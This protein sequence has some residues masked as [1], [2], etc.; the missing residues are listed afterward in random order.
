MNIRIIL[1][2]LVVGLISFGGFLYSSQCVE[3]KTKEIDI[4]FRGEARSNSLYASR[5]FLKKMGIPAEKVDIY[6]LRDLPS[7]KTV[8]L[9]NTYR[10]TLVNY[11]INQ[12][13]DWVKGGGHLI[14]VVI[15]ERDIGEEGDLLQMKL[16]INTEEIYNFKSHFL[17]KQNEQ[18]KKDKKAGKKV[19]KNK[20]EFDPTFKVSF[21][22]SEKTY[23]LDFLTIDPLSILEDKTKKSDEIIMVDEAA[24][25]L[26]R[27]Y[28]KG[29]ISI[30]SDLDIIENRMIEDEDHA[31]FFWQLV[32]RKH[33]TIDNVWLINTD[34]MPSLIAWLWGYGWQIILTLSL[35][36]VFWLYSLSHRLGPVI[37]SE[38]LN[39]RRL[40]EHIQASGYFFWKKNQQD[41]LINSSQQA[42]LQK[43]GKLFPEW[44]QLTVDE[45]LALASEYTDIPIKELSPL[46]F[47]N[48][49]LTIDEFI[50]RIQQLEAIRKH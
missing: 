23:G 48:K 45:Q 34:E 12:L 24:Y 18:L 14:T 40:L 9:I 31:E 38:A 16:G 22:D 46:L 47:E 29:L 33:R 27:Q 5:L 1:G 7:K 39:R 17:E 37:P 4:G 43:I 2:V 20:V 49:T 44:S 11:Q 6:H 3:T 13:M 30:A 21:K 10:S 36:L 42:A 26:N 19:S 25:L 28:G 8:I 32:H 41:K 35:F 15:P 50:Q